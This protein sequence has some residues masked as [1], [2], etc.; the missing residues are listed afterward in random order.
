MAKP[1][2]NKMQNVKGKLKGKPPWTEA[3]LQLP[4][5]L[6]KVNPNE[7]PSVQFYPIT[8]KPFS[9]FF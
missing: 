9:L 8:E 3:S 5:P 1:N 7:L 4:Q 6:S 2:F